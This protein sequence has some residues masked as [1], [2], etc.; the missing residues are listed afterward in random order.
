MNAPVPPRPPAGRAY[1]VVVAG[2]VNVDLV[3][4]V[5]RR[6][7]AGET[8]LGSD[9]ATH[10]GGKGANQAVAA[11][12]LGGRVAFA[13]RA[14]T[15]GNG[16][17]V[18]ETLRRDGVDIAYLTTTPG[19]NGV[20]L[21]T[22]DPSGDNSIIVSPGANAKVTEE[23]VAAARPLFADAAVVSLQLEIPLAA[24]VAAARTADE[25][26]AR[27]VFNLSP[28]ADV[29]DE[30]I[31]RCDPLVVNEHE[32]EFLGDTRPA[33]LLARGARSVVITRGARGAVVA[34]ADGV[35]EVP[36][37]RVDVVDTTGA[38]DAFTGALC[39]RLARG[40]DLASAA[41]FAARVGAAAVRRAGAQT[42][43][44]TPEDL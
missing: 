27:V 31:A 23:D 25:E 28:A 42:S 20:A 44:P 7:A 9:L 41:R 2:S 32:A 38:G 35:T 15:D 5:E 18:R 43:F 17:L 16:D 40:D 29:P 22:V 4:G 1:D 37:P 13:G 34:D 24:V 26:G 19:P 30:L 21:I 11:A 14:G 33:G 12:R 39:L 8:V 36:S 3:V 6:P 10:P